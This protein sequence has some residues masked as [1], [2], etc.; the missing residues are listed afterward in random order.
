VKTVAIEKSLSVAY[1][2]RASELFDAM[3]D[4]DDLKRHNAAAL[5]GVHAA[6]ALADALTILIAGK[7]AATKPTAIL[8]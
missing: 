4:E 5:L 2:N 1:R 7:R 6:I 8:C 3:K